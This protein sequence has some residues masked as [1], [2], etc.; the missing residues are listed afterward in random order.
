MPIKNGLQ[1]KERLDRNRPDIRI[2]G[3]QVQ[4]KVSEHA[5]F[6]GLMA[7]QASM[8]DMQ[9]DESAKARM[10]FESPLSGERVGLSFLQPKTKKD[11]AARRE[12]MQAWAYAHNGF[13]GRAPDYMNTALMAY[14]SAAGILEKDYPQFAANLRNYY[15]YCRENDITLSHVFIQPKAARLSNFLLALE[16]PPAAR[17]MEKNKD[18]IIVRG[19]F[20]L[21]TQGATSDEILVYPAPFPTFHEGES[22]YSFFFAVPSCLPGIRFVCRESFVGGESAYDYP[23][24]SR[25]EEMDTLVLFEDVLVPWDRVFLCG[26][27]SMANR[28]SEESRFHTHAATQVMCKNIAKTEFFLG[29]A[30]TMA[31][32]SGIDQNAHVV[33]M[34]SE[35]L[36]IL[37]TLKSLQLA[38]ENG[39]K[40]DKWGSMVP[41]PKP[42]LAANVY[43]PKVYPRMIEII[44]LIG[45]SSVIMI[46]SEK[47]FDGKL[48]DLLQRYLKGVGLDAKN[49][50]QLSRLAWE[51]SVSAFGGRQSVYEKFFFGNAATVTNRLYNGYE[52]REKYKQRILDF[53]SEK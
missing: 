1:Y 44:H 36:V 47:D 52:G 13:L 12:M 43:F 5:A 45:S 26:D 27:V 2:A 23:L 30:E 7:T 8:Y 6:K 37:E 38:A 40:R 53:L 16:N 31:E 48:G 41:D 24:S 46:P 32:T 20:M 42:L 28:L 18:G 17:V 34:V 33:E 21:D 35:L 19:A 3:Q 9:A 50:V 14:S 49:N 4:G 10:T 15:V 22:P 11:L 29:V 51:L 25:Y 39:A